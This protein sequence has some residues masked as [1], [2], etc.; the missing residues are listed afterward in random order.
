VAAC[1]SHAAEQHHFTDEQIF[2]EIEGVL[3]A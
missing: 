1:P 3:V 2:A